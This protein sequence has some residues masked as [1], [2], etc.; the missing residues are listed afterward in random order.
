MLVGGGGEPVLSASVAEECNR[1]SGQGSTEGEGR[2]FADLAHKA[3]VRELDEWE[4]VRV[5][6]PE[7]G[8]PV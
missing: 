4:H 3:K 1:I 7:I 6:S 8:R 2:T 5:I